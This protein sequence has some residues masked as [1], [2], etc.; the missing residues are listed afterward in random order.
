M[1][2]LHP[3]RSGLILIVLG[4]LVWI[5][6]DQASEPA[7]EEAARTFVNPLYEGADPF[8]YKHTDGIY[9]FCESEGDGGISIWK[10]DRLT[11]KGVR[12]VVWTP[13]AEGWN[14]SEIWAPELHY[15]SGKWY[16]YY[17]ADSGE[18]KDHRMGVLESVTDD[19]QG[20]YTDKGMLYTGDESENTGDESEGN[21]RWAIDGTP[22]KVGDRLYFIWSGWEGTVD[23][24]W[25]YIAEME[26][27][28]TIKTNR[29]KLAENDDYSWERVSESADE[30]GLNEGPQILE[31]AGVIYVV[32]SVSGSW[33]TSYKLAQLSIEAGADPME[34]SN[35]VK[36][37]NPVFT[38]S[39][40][41]YGVGHASFTTS[42]DGSEDWLVYHTK[43]DTVPGWRR[44]VHMQPFAWTEQGP[45]F[46]DPVPAGVPLAVPSGEPINAPG[47]H[48]SD[49]FEDGRW[50]NWVYY[51]HNQFINTQNGA[52]SLSSI[53]DQHTHDTFPSGEK[54]L[55]RGYDWV[56]FT[57]S[58][59][60]NV[61]EGEGEAGL[62][63]RA[64]HPGVG[65][66]AVKGYYSALRP[67]EDA[68]VLGTIDGGT[69]KEL[70]RAELHSSNDE[71]YEMTIRAA[72][73]QI[74][75]E[76]NGEPMIRVEDNTHASGMAG[77]RIVDVHALFDDVDVRADDV[78]IP[79][80][81]N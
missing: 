30:R 68:V 60:I 67:R 37:D 55:I 56:D 57:F 28:W 72:G 2:R 22:L 65:H 26:N 45:D 74:S 7:A 66:H 51:G 69:W 10:S 52:L 31:R 61:L 34:P 39:D 1:K 43:I 5:G 80:A 59:R 14:T 3:H 17:A 62:L 27:P 50:D 49:T 6:C 18:N 40:R 64:L 81:Q 29:V 15:L 21:N 46:G 63:F 54:A 12:R 75:L 33:Q 4:V 23:E 25:L 71:W 42:P 58:T 19:P 53:P 8:V 36:H 76:V 70:A 77:V 44:V 20:E 16:I 41:V 78:D 24:Q 48:F 32:Y 79:A 47:E 35:W 11:D 13:P 9:Y 38:G 73:A